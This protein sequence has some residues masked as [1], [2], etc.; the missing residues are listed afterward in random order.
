MNNTFQNFSDEQVAA[1]YENLKSH[2]KSEDEIFTEIYALDCSQD[3]E[4]QE[5][6]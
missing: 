6:E 4:N 3:E 5:E 1:M 2:G